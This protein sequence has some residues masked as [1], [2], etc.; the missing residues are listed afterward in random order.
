[1][2]SVNILSLGMFCVI[3]SLDMYNSRQKKRAI[4]TF[5]ERLQ[6]TMFLGRKP[7]LGLRRWVNFDP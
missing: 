7:T 2:Q 5:V 4:P 3:S 6:L 1:M